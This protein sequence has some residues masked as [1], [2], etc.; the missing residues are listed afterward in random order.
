MSI[1]N[2]FPY[3]RYCVYRKCPS[4]GWKIDTRTIQ[5][6][7]FVLIT[8]GE[9]K[10]TISNNI[11]TARK[12]MFFYFYPGLP[13]SLRSSTEEPLSFYAIHFSFTYLNYSNNGWKIDK[14]TRLLPIQSVFETASF[15]KLKHLLRSLIDQWKQKDPN[16]ELAVNGL[17]LQFIHTVLQDQR[18][19]KAKYSSRQ[20][21]EEVINYIESNLNRKLT[22][23]HLAQAV[24]LSPDYL[25]AIFKSCTGYPLMQYVNKC[26]IDKAK[27]YLDEGIYKVKDV[28][29]LLGFKD[30]FHFSKVFKKYVGMS[31]REFYRKICAENPVN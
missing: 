12:G 24:D 4:S 21:V 18:T 5:D 6:H 31:P 25:S 15:H 20:K 14:N 27:I 30:E 1:I 16:Y 26:R 22:V 19:S 11:H 23:S 3:I 13:H 17:F 8:A 7:E 2:F 10:I 9:G 29:A 28:A